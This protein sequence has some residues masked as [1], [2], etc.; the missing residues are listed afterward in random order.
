[1]AR[2][3]VLCRTIPWPMIL[4]T[5]S[6]LWFYILYIYICAHLLYARRPSMQHVQQDPLP[7]PYRLSR[8][9]SPIARP[10]T[11]RNIAREE[12]HVQQDPLPSPSRPSPRRSLRSSS[13][14]PLSLLPP[15]NTSHPP[16]NTSHPV[17]LLNK[18]AHGRAGARLYET[19]STF[20]KL[21]GFT[22]ELVPGENIPCPVSDQTG[23]FGLC[24]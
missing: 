16:S 10:S 17:L 3:I 23:H 12:Q 18:K 9:R 6:M 11:R 15:S 14:P 22:D 2:L 7:G 1:M 13:Q 24:S 4:Y 5:C 19:Q 21:M 8:E 20:M